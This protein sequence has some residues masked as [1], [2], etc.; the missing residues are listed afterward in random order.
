MVDIKFKNYF[1]P[2]EWKECYIQQLTFRYKQD[3]LL[4]KTIMHLI[5]IV[6]NV[7]P[8]KKYTV[9]VQIIF[10][11]KSLFLIVTPYLNFLSVRL[12]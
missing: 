4:K 2:S 1:S 10:G 6:T 11:G 5:A 3:H 9:V 8:C 7:L 12:L